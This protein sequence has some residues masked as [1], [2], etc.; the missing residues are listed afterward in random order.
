MEESPSG[1]IPSPTRQILDNKISEESSLPIAHDALIDKRKNEIENNKKMNKLDILD[2]LDMVDEVDR[3]DA[4]ETMNIIKGKS[5]RSAARRRGILKEKE[6]D[7]KIQ[8]EFCLTSTD[9]ILQST[10]NTMEMINK[11]LTEQ[12][13]N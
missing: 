12:G 2:S 10:N 13:K 1:Q 3:V 8:Q 4:A 11:S 7:R 9:F 5:R 6:E